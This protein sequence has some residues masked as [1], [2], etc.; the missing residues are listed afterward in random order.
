M[1]NFGL[2]IIDESVLTNLGNTSLTS[3][4]YGSTLIAHEL[5]HHWAGDLV[6]MN[7]FADLWLNEALAEFFQYIPFNS[8]PFPEL[9]N[10]TDIFYLNEHNLAFY[11]GEETFPFN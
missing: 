8:G 5:A 4:Q 7:S 9:I 2:I 1:E 3:L 10:V 11:A 6:T